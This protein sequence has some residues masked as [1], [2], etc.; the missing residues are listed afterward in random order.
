MRSLPNDL[1]GDKERT[2]NY[3]ECDCGKWKEKSEVITTNPVRNGSEYVYIWTFNHNSTSKIYF[4]ILWLTG[5]VW[6]VSA[7]RERLTRKH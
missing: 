7:L 5:K 3:K 4:Y 2:A 6:Y 1:E